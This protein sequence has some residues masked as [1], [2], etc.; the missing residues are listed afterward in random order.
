ML[1][2]WKKG[3]RK[4]EQFL[5]LDQTWKTLQTSN[6]NLCRFMKSTLYYTEEIWMNPV[7]G[8]LHPGRRFDWQ[9]C[10]LCS[11]HTCFLDSMQTIAL[12]LFSFSN[13]MSAISPFVIEVFSASF[14]F[15]FCPCRFL[16]SSSWR[17]KTAPV[18]LQP[19]SH[20]RQMKQSPPPLPIPI[21]AFL[22]S[23]PPPLS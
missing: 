17:R 10:G 12:Y 16:S 20:L 4:E 14:F 13:G 22:P 7:L 11:F 8:K 1:S 18:T 3:V 23:P 6:W 9:I 15:F 21:P 2:T 5:I 19:Q